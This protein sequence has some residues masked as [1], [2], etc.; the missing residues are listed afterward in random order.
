[1]REEIRRPKVDLDYDRLREIVS[2]AYRM[3]EEYAGSKMIP[4]RA[5]VME[6]L[7]RQLA[8][9]LTAAL[10]V[11]PIGCEKIPDLALRVD[12]KRRKVHLLSSQK[13]RAA[14]MNRYMRI[15]G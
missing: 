9:G 13:K 6:R 1:M 4:D 7:E 10:F 15:L 11:I 8:C 2:E 12:P 5:S 14:R 3:V